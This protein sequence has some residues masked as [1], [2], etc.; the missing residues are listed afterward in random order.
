V[1][2][3]SVCV[4][5]SGCLCVSLGSW[6]LCVG[7]GGPVRGCLCLESISESTCTVSVGVTCRDQGANVTGS[8]LSHVLGG[9]RGKRGKHASWGDVTRDRQYTGDVTRECQY[10]KPCKWRRW[11]YAGGKEHR[12]P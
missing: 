1:A 5:H 12:T 3:S 7:V 8:R 6:V 11:V 9:R 2:F 4:C 10:T